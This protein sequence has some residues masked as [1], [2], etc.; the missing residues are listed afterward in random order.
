[1]PMIHTIFQE[2][3]LSQP[4]IQELPEQSQKELLEQVHVWKYRMGQPMLVLKRKPK[5]VLVLY[6]GGARCVYLDPRS[7]KLVTIQRFI[8]GD[9]IG[10]LSALRGY[11]C[12]NI[13][14]TDESVA[15]AIPAQLFTE[16]WEHQ[17]NWRKFFS[18]QAI[19]IE[20]AEMINFELSETAYQVMTIP[21]REWVSQLK[22]KLVALSP[23]PLVIPDI[24]NVRWW[25]SLGEIGNQREGSWLNL[26]ESKLEVKCPTRLIG[27]IGSVIVPELCVDNQVTSDEEDVAEMEL[28]YAPSGEEEEV[29]HEQQYPFCRGEGKIGGALACYQMLCKY[30]KIP[31]RKEVLRRVLESRSR[32]VSQISLELAGA[33]A[34][35][36]GLNSQLLNIPKHLFA[37]VEAPALMQWQG[38]L[39][40]VF[41]ISAS[42]I[43][44]GV[45]DQ[46]IVKCKP[47]EVLS[48]WEDQNSIYIVKLKKSIYTPQERF[49]FSWFW[50]YLWRYRKVLFEVLLASFFVQLFGLANPLMIQIIIDKVLVQNSINS[51]NVLGILLLGAAIAEAVLGA[52]R[53]YLFVDT[54]N[55]IDMALGSQVI[56]HLL[57]LPLRYYERRPVGELSTRV[58]ELE[59]I[60]QFLTGT[61]LSSVLD[62]IFSVVYI[63]VMVIYSWL[64][65]LVALATIPLFILLTLLAAPIIRRQLRVRAERYAQTQ[66]YFSEVL[67]GILT[68]KAQNLELTA[69]WKWQA[70]YAR[71]I[72]TGFRTVITSTAA[73]SIS[74]FL[75]QTSSLLLLWVGAFLV[76]KGQ[77][78][79]GQL[80]A[81]RII[82]GYTTSPLLR[83]VQ[84]WQNFQQTA[85]SL[86]RLADI[87]DTPQET[88]LDDS[89]N[90]S[91]PR[92]IGGIRFE[93]V[94]FR[95]NANSPLQLTNICL[96]IKPGSLVGIV[97][98]SG[99][100]KSTLTKLISRLYIPESGR[101]Y[102]D[103]FDIAKVNLYSLREQIGVVLQ[104]PLLFDGTVQENIAI[105]N[106]GLPIESIINV[107]KIACAH[108]FIM[109]LP[110]G[111]NTRVGERGNMLS[112]GQRQRIALAR[113]LL[114]Q[115]RLLI[116]DEATSALDYNTEFQVCKNLAKAFKGKTI[117]FITHRLSTLREADRIIL[118][119]EGRI[120]E[121]GTHEV[122]LQMRGRYYSLYQKQG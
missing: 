102:I 3:L 50:P 111:Y 69:R 70:R 33:V 77:L 109:N 36:M 19:P 78:T 72:A 42:E 67:G 14:A 84:L 39:V 79:L 4:Y 44:F 71:Y 61:A 89:K 118:M 101:I 49:G 17:V 95:F 52:L 59:S 18:R 119:D 113:V 21:L 121:D 105:G 75:N 25:I 37:K 87:V 43:V 91:M 32:H 103:N 51:L 104:D 97:G 83:L 6:K 45:P 28:S 62:A 23:G 20:I 30:F 114:Q 58:N 24:P 22:V 48:E 63:V 107:A 106:S 112:G 94:N 120:V 110:Q 47:K 5:Y 85:L 13:I 34:E 31:F 93:D 65:T 9:V 15:I 73:S 35:V 96:D 92:I 99:S 98:E 86:E 88:D 81:F 41:H 68:V 2:F 76:L 80:I 16:L 53:T 60:R 57:R 116:L 122:L 74:H 7:N 1:M 90:I 27:I 64:L 12:E 100:G 54:T 82:A 46:G 55:R 40:V 66:A 56:D 10:W 8:K 108:D 11:T 117:L 29:L 26:G 115:P 38:K